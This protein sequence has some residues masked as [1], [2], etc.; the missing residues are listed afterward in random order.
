MRRVVSN[1]HPYPGVAAL[2]YALIRTVFYL[3]DKASIATGMVKVPRPYIWTGW[4]AFEAYRV[5]YWNARPR[6]QPDIAIRNMAG[7]GRTPR[8][9]FYN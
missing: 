8:S 6:L 2:G 1:S 7:P 5:W 9:S 3:I 4:I